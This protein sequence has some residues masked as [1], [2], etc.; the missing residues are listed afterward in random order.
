MNKNFSVL[1]F[2]LVATIQQI[3]E[4][5]CFYGKFHWIALSEHLWYV[6]EKTEILALCRLYKPSTSKTESEILWWEQHKEFQLW[7][8]WGDG[9]QVWIQSVQSS[10]HG[11]GDLWAGL[12][13]KNLR[14]WA[15]QQR[16]RSRFSRS[17]TG[18]GVSG[19]GA[20]HWWCDPSQSPS[21]CLVPLSSVTCDNVCPCSK[22][23]SNEVTST[24]RSH[25]AWHPGSPQLVIAALVSPL[26]LPPRLFLCLCVA[27]TT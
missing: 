3:K 19:Q 12:R 18:V 17:Q 6:G 9:I 14:P 10:P 25:G 11:E 20:L 26:L 5:F 8:K 4:H 23:E 15:I 13:A 2:W 27:M 22:W 1:F 24:A 21:T 16:T 7:E